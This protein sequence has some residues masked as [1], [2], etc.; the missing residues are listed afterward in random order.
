M[1]ELSIAEAIINSLKNIKAKYP[2]NV[3]KNVK[4][5][6]GKFQMIIPDA[7]MFYLDI[8][9]KGTEF[10]E[11]RF[12]FQ[13]ESLKARC[14]KC[15]KEFETS[16]LDFICPSCGSNEIE[17]LNGTELYIEKIEIEWKSYTFIIVQKFKKYSISSYNDLVKSL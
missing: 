12:T 14:K 1:H 3:I 10:N 11:T 13:E 6:Y 9:K 5:N 7:L 15:N 16:E 17:Y 2:D 8:L 4:I